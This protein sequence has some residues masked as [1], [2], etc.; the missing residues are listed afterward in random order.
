MLPEILGL[1][2][3]EAQG[4]GEEEKKSLQHSCGGVQVVGKNLALFPLT[5]DRFFYG[6]QSHIWTQEPIFPGI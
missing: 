6:G 1:W 3:G 2:S 5:W 4:S